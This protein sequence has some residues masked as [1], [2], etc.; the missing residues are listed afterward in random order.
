M[1]NRIFVVI[2]LSA[3]RIDIFHKALQSVYM[4]RF[5]HQADI[6]IIISCDSCTKEQ[7]SKV[8]KLASQCKNNQLLMTQVIENTRT[9]KHSGTGAWNSAALLALSKH[10]YGDNLTHSY[11]AFLDDDDTW[12][13]GYLQEC[14]DVLCGRNNIALIAAGINRY[15]DGILKEIVLPN[16]DLLTQE[17]IFVQNPGIQGSN[18]FV[19]LGVF[20]AIGGFDESMPSTTDRDL[21]MRYVDYICVMPYET[22]IITKPLVNHYADSNRVR[23]SNNAIVKHKGLDLFY[24]KYYTLF[25]KE[26]QDQSL[27]RA[28]KLFG[29]QRSEVAL[30]PP[31]CDAGQTQFDSRKIRLILSFACFDERNAQELCASLQK[32][33]PLQHNALESF[34]ICILTTYT[35]E[36]TMKQVFSLYITHFKTL[37]EQPHIA[38]SRTLLQQ[39]T[40]EIGM[41]HYKDSFVSWIID[42]DLRFCVFNG[43]QEYPIDYFSHIANL[44]S[45]GIDCAF[46][47]VVGEP[48]LP[49]FSTL[50]GQMLD[51]YYAILGAN[52]C[53]EASGEY[54]YDLSSCNFEFL[55]YPFFSSNSSESMIEKLQ[56]GR[57][58]TRMLVAKQNIGA[59]QRDSIY[60]GGNSI[61]Y[62]PTLLQLENFT[63]HEGYNR[64][65]DFN[66]AIIHKTLHN[67]TLKSVNLPLLHVRRG[68]EID[69]EREKI[70]SDLIGMIFYRV[71]LDFCESFAR[72]G[73]C[74][75]YAQT[76]RKFYDEIAKLKLKLRANVL[77]LK[78]LDR[79]IK[80]KLHNEVVRHSYH[81][82]SQRVC[83]A[84]SELERFCQEELEL[85]RSVYLKMTSVLK[86]K[87]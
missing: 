21:L 44:S 29:Y 71:F 64:R 12:E 26:L 8:E 25:N 53:N 87:S 57:I 30:S 4:Q 79:L 77:R 60:R 42:D 68:I 3:E 10:D 11:L 86:S 84:V 35:L 31:I 78:A 32:L 7:R 80:A 18:L 52:G 51:L 38:A 13:E 75:D 28:K 59:I 37:S 69:V 70:R 14:L 49:F 33:A 83:A 2:A 27:E 15:E 46:G 19:N 56:N 67:H 55:E 5:T 17:N 82:V 58:A 81:C 40:Y 34:R 41:T 74:L 48:P 47:G 24:R 22:A 23:V 54:Y 63:P 16:Q 20:F 72:S 66:W 36:H 76:Q 1:R 9:K 45:K 61:I 50:R 43:V 6:E 39:F 62:N 73:V 65:S 85:E